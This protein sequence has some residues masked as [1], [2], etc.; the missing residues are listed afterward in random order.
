MLSFLPRFFSQIDQRAL[1]RLH[2]RRLI[3]PK[4]SPAIST[5]T[6]ICLPVCFGFAIQRHNQSPTFNHENPDSGPPILSAISV[7]AC[8]SASSAQRFS[9]LP[10]VG[11]LS[12]KDP[13]PPAVP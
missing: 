1:Y 10:K 3:P 13:F 2:F 4:N 12:H 7:T 8:P 6:F 5:P 11:E 9:S